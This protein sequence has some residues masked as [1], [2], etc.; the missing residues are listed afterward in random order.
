MIQIMERDVGLMQWMLEQKFM[1]AGQVRSV[2]WKEAKA[3]SKE[4]HRRLRELE[5]AGFI[6]RS[7][8][9]IFRFLLYVVTKQGLKVLSSLGNTR[10]LSVLDDVDYSSY[11]HDSEVTDLRIWFHNQ[12]FT[13][14]LSERVLAKHYSL[15]HLPDGML[16][17]DGKYL[18][19][20]YETAQKS[21]QRYRH[22][23]YSYELED[24][25]SEVLYIV[26]S[27]RLKSKLK[28][29]AATCE[30]IHFRT[31]GDLKGHLADTS[32][33]ELKFFTGKGY[34]CAC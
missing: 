7:G 32:L 28:A 4:V 9:D 31:P 33:G 12:G 24:Q 2:F 17:H 10:G 15:R 26:G 21:S 6:K 29:M 18:A 27:D 20:E 3:E 14:W 30:K 8:K 16:Y 1:D 34:A 25:A 23:I 13:E 11:R 22:I 19:I 5:K